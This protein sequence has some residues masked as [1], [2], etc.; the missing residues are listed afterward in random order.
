MNRLGFRSS[1][2]L[3]VFL[4]VMSIS[5]WALAQPQSFSAEGVIVPR[6]QATLTP[7]VPGRLNELHWKEG[8]RVKKGDLIARLDETEQR[9]ELDLVRAESQQVKA[10]LLREMAAKDGL[11]RL[12][13]EI[14]RATAELSRAKTELMRME[15]LAAKQVINADELDLVRAEAESKEHAVAGLKIERNVAETAAKAGVLIAE[16]NLAAAEARMKLAEYRLDNCVIR[17]PF[18]GVIAEVTANPGEVVG[19]EGGP[20]SVCRI[21]D[22]SQP[23]AEVRVPVQRTSAVSAG[24]DCRVSLASAERPIGGRVRSVGSIVTD[25]FVTVRIDLEETEDG[26]RI[27]PGTPIVVE[28]QR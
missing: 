25:G 4:S 16:A 7:Q 5:A 21:V 10:E 2:S 13:A 20:A 26:N 3:V 18:D 14:A 24:E 12:E 27:L 17:A 15:R 8:D 22:I 23:L 6:Q 11:T 19:R 1:V 9:L 28:I